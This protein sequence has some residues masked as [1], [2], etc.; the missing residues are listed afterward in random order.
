MGWGGGK[1]LLESYENTEKN[2]RLKNTWQPKHILSTAAPALGQ[3]LE[4]D[5]L[6]NLSQT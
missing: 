4:L 2:S 5:D 3:E 1:E 6:W